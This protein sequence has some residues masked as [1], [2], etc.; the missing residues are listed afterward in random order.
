MTRT[1]ET[2]QRHPIT[3]MMI[4]AVFVES[5]G[6]EAEVDARLRGPENRQASACA[7]V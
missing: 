4:S 7:F 1:A 5:S 2:V 6:R 3:A